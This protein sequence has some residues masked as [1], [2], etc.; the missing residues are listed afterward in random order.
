MKQ[1]I[2]TNGIMA[3]TNL[4][5]KEKQSLMETLNKAIV[6]FEKKRDSLQR[7]S[8]DRSYLKDTVECLKKAKS[9]FVNIW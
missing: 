5:S 9:A 1:L 3:K 7:G 8:Y 6:K 2:K 4:T